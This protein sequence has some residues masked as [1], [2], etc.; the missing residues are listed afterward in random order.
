MNTSIKSR[1]ARRRPEDRPDEILSAALEIFTENGFATARVED[2]AKRAGLSKGAVYLYFDSKEA[3]LKAL[4]EQSAGRIVNAASTLSMMGAEQDPE[5]T[6]RAILKMAL[7]ALADPDISAAPRLVLAEAGQ[8]P[9]LA[10]FY[11][12]RVIEVGRMAMRHL[13]EEGRKSGRFRDIPSEAALLTFIG[14]AVAQM[15]LSTVFRLEDDPE[16]DPS[17]LAD[18]IADIVLNGLKTRSANDA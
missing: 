17:E 3:M 7:I 15:M 4:V 14:P 16:P 8:F 5:A 6:Y 2:I 9:E 1:P 12:K 11:R 10:Q 18:A 13:V